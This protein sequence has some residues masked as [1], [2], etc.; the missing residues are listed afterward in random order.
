MSLFGDDV[1]FAR[2][3]F[4]CNAVHIPLHF[5]I[6]DAGHG[7]VMIIGA[8]RSPSPGAAHPLRFGSSMTHQLFKGDAVFRP[9]WV[10]ELDDLKGA[11]GASLVT[12][13][14]FC[15]PSQWKTILD[16]QV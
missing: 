10:G 8:S 4:G 14:A 16:M 5:A 7:I 13:G 9:H 1:D 6:Q 12:S 11:G 15:D 3:M 2:V